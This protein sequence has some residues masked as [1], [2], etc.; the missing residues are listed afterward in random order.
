MRSSSIIPT[1]CRWIQGQAHAVV[2]NRIL[3]IF[4]SSCTAL[5]YHLSIL[6][7]SYVLILVAWSILF[8]FSYSTIGRQ[9]ARCVILLQSEGSYEGWSSANVCTREFLQQ[10]YDQAVSQPHLTKLYA[11]TTIYHV[12]RIKDLFLE[13]DYPSSKPSVRR[14]IRFF[15]AVRY[16][17]LFELK[18]RETLKESLTARIKNFLHW[19]LKK[20][21]I[22]KTSTVTTYW[23][24]LSQLH[25]LWW[26]HWV[27]PTVLRQIFVVWCLDLACIPAYWSN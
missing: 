16:C 20:Y 2:D 12:N 8:S 23:R 10:K 9:K 3:Y 17:S 1:P 24:Q 19:I 13:Y 18:P 21:N 27:E 22:K 4:L 14:L 6:W 15:Y 11:D 25:I 5:D 26:N 7:P